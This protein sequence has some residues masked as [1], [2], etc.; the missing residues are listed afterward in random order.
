MKAEN[1]DKQMG[2]TD[3]SNTNKIQE[4]EER[5]SSIEVTIKDIYK[6]VKEDVPLK[7]IL[8]QNI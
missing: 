1:L 4:K 6:L 5:I 8:P 7:K 3:A 2:M